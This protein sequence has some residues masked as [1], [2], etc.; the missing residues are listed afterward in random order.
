MLNFNGLN[1]HKVVVLETEVPDYNFD[2]YEC[3]Q[4]NRWTQ[5]RHNDAIASLKKGWSLFE[6][7]ETRDGRFFRVTSSSVVEFTSEG[8]IRVHPLETAMFW[9]KQT[10]RVHTVAARGFEALYLIES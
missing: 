8:A 10:I 1:R 2:G 9:A 3:F 7:V 4:A 5:E 6:I